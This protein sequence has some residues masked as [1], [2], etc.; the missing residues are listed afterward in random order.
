[1]PTVIASFVRVVVVMPIRVVGMLSFRS[2][3]ALFLGNRE[4]FRAFTSLFFLTDAGFFPIKIGQ[5]D[6]NLVEN[7]HRQRHDHQRERIR[8]R[9]QD[10]SGYENSDDGVG[11]CLRHRFIAEQSELHEDH[12]DHRQLEGC[13][14]QQRKLGGEGNVFSDSPVVGNPHVATPLIE[15][16]QRP[17]QHHIVGKCRAA[18]KQSE[19]HGHRRP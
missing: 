3:S 5:P 12:D 17:R 14:E 2:G 15:K 18:K 10:R 4:P 6:A 19:A 7:N 11:T 8:G 1:M 9:C 13:S 16:Q